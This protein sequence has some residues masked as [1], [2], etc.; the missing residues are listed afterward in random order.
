MQS[1]YFKHFDENEIFDWHLKILAERAAAV[2]AG[3]AQID[4]WEV[5]KMKIHERLNIVITN[6]YVG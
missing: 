5:A 2:K 1:E 3:T 4:D 6:A